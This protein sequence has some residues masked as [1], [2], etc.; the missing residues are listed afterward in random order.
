MLRFSVDF[1]AQRELK[2]TLTAK[3]Q[4][5]IVFK[6]YSVLYQKAK[7]S[8]SKEEVRVLPGGVGKLFTTED[9][10]LE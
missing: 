7:Q 8:G 6:E 3:K 9:A 5:R 1:E 4:T 2:V 10:T